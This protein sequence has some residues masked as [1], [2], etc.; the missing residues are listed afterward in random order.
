MAET[1]KSTHDELKDCI[2]RLKKHTEVM[3]AE[4]GRDYDLKHAKVAHAEKEVVKAAQA[5]L[6][7]MK[8][9]GVK[10]E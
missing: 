8:D 4:K 3:E 9:A 10:F 6:K 1:L 5:L 7:S 2:G